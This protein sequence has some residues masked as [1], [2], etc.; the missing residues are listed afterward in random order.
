[1]AAERKLFELYYGY[2]LSICQQYGKSKQE[3]EEMLNDTF[4][5]V[6]RYLVRY[7]EQYDFKPWLR[8]VCV[9]S[10]LKY[11]K[12][13]RI[14]FETEELTQ[15]TENRNVELADDISSDHVFKI[16][17]QLPRAYRIVFNLYV[18]EEYKHHEIA[19]LLG[20]SVGTSKS[21]LSRAKMKL[22]E[23]IMKSNLSPSKKR[24]S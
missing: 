14:E 21:N 17:N 2:V 24:Y 19:E 7:D 11:L 23:I 22:E 1:L 10:C 9:N 3:F 16:I 5:T 18:I 13:Y 8:K 15:R 4:Y 20:I 12:K 6:F